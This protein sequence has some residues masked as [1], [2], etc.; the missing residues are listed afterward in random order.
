MLLPYS[1]LMR[2][3]LRSA[4]ERSAVAEMPGYFASNALA[5]AVTSC[6]S[7]EPYQ[8][9]APSFLAASI[10]SGVTG[11]GSIAPAPA[12]SRVSTEERCD[13]KSNRLFAAD[14]L[15]EKFQIPQ[16]QGMPAS[17]RPFGPFGGGNVHNCLAISGASRTATAQAEGGLRISE[18]LPEI[19]YLLLLA[20]SQAYTSGGRN[21]A[22]RL[23]QSSTIFT[24]SELTVMLPSR[25]TS[26]AP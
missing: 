26:S 2:W 20:L 9:T 19:R 1:W 25:S 10:S 11:L 6:R 3:K 4:P 14:L 15:V 16:Y 24:G 22:S 12:L 18:P 23:N 17:I 8:T 7:S 21:G 13:R 5:T